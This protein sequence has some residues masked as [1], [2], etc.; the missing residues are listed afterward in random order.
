MHRLRLNRQVLLM[1]FATVEESHRLL[2]LIAKLKGPVR[3][4][5]PPEDIAEICALFEMWDKR[6]RTRLAS[7]EAETGQQGPEGS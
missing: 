5:P 1:G 2:A 4:K 7:H 6:L 3:V